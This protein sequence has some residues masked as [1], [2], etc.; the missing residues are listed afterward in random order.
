MPEAPFDFEDIGRRVDGLLHLAQW[1]ERA[2][3][4]TS[5]IEAAADRDP[6]LNARLRDKG[7]PFGDCWW[8][9]EEHNGYL[10][11]LRLAVIDVRSMAE[12]GRALTRQPPRPQPSH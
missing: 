5:D 7:I 10:E 12:A 6:T 9:Y 11:L 1:I 3:S 2:R 4:L 8:E